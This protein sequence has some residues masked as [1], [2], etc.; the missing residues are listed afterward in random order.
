[1]DV[2]GGDWLLQ[3]REDRGLVANTD[4]RHDEHGYVSAAANSMAN[5][6]KPRER[7]VAMQDGD[8]PSPVRSNIGMSL[9]K[10]NASQLDDG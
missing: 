3:R 10:P 4:G 5:H 6:S 9:N 2:S 8:G 7:R 1:M